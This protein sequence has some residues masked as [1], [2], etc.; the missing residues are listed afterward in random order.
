MSQFACD[1]KEGREWMC[2]SNPADW[3][4]FASLNDLA[5]MTACKDGGT[6]CDTTWYAT[7]A[8]VPVYPT[9]SYNNC[10][11]PHK[12]TLQTDQNYAQNPKGFVNVTA[13]KTYLYSSDKETTIDGKTMQYSDDHVYYKPGHT[14][15]LDPPY[16]LMYPENACTNGTLA[17][18]K[19]DQLSGHANF[20]TKDPRVDDFN[21]PPKPATL[22]N[23]GTCACKAGYVGYFCDHTQA[24]ANEVCHNNG[25]GVTSDDPTKPIACQCDSNTLGDYCEISTKNCS[26]QGVPVGTKDKYV[27]ICDP[28]KAKGP[29]CS[30]SFK[31]AA[32][33]FYRNKNYTDPVKT[34]TLD[35]PTR[36]Q[37]GNLNPWGGNYGEFVVSPDDHQMVAD[38]GGGQWTDLYWTPHTVN[39]GGDPYH[40]C[41]TCAQSLIVDFGDWKELYLNYYLIAVGL[42]THGSPCTALKIVPTS[43]NTFKIPDIKAWLLKQPHV[44][45][46]FLANKITY[47]ER[48]IN[49]SL[50]TGPVSSVCSK[51]QGSRITWSPASAHAVK[52]DGKTPCSKACGPNQCFGGWDAT[53]NIPVDGQSVADYCICSGSGPGV[54]AGYCSCKCVQ[55]SSSDPYAKTPEVDQNHCISG[56]TPH[57]G[58][59]TACMMQTCDCSCK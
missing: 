25:K 4:Q 28:A 12:N 38:T 26:G 52:S 51:V 37:Y 41:G 23:V 7:T 44:D 19:K 49:M 36:T 31:N 10:A 35:G 15:A 13:N 24:E 48:H 56:T 45:P 27:C 47:E 59:T 21:N 3:C 33:T 2:P 18:Q 40:T 57:V 16:C 34:V 9:I 54:A 58:S 14:Q 20:S 43:T 29:T 42:G 53:N 8:G 5:P 17:I 6:A 30:T 1:G 39:D 50:S 55:K 32:I 22:P 11:V 46:V